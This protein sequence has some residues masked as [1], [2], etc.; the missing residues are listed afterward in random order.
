[1]AN[2]MSIGQKVGTRV[3][4]PK[5]FWRLKNDRLYLQKFKPLQ[6]YQVQDMTQFQL[7]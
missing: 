7:H 2:H 1:M 5:I 4:E 3:A 6:P